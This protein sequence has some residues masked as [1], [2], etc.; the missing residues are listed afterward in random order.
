MTAAGDF[1]YGRRFVPD[2]EGGLTSKWGYLVPWPQ[3]Q[4]YLA[5][6]GGFN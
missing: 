4:V 2:G 3:L 5:H 1:G 6:T